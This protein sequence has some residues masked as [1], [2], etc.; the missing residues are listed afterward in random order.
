MGITTH[1]NA[2]YIAIADVH[3]GNPRLQ[4]SN[5][6]LK[7]QK[8][9]YPLLALPEDHIDHVDVLFVCGDFFDTLLTMNTESSIV[10]VK[11]I[12][13]LV[14]LAI[15]HNFLIRVIRGTYTHD[16]NQ[17]RFFLKY[18]GR[19]NNIVKVYETL[20]MEYIESIDKW[21]MYTPDNLPYENQMS[22]MEDIMRDNQ[23]DQ[24]DILVNHGYFDFELPPNVPIPHNMLVSEEVRRKIIPHGFC[25]SGHVHTPGYCDGVISIGSFDRFAHGEEGCK[26]GFYIIRDRNGVISQEHVDNDDACVFA[27]IV[28][29]DNDDP[30]HNEYG[31][32]EKWFKQL[33]SNLPALAK[34]AHVRL[35]GDDVSLV[36]ACAKLAR[37][38]YP[39]VIIDKCVETTKDQILDNVN[40]HLEDLPVITKGNVSELMLPIIQ[41]QYPNATLQDVLDVLECCEKTSK[42]EGDDLS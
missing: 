31:R 19:D 41:K 1:R 21:V 8:N 11:I 34:Q 18:L 32:F 10:A 3:I 42:K 22:V 30:D 27:T 37:T 24:I 9:L 26:K 6:Y 35:K 36:E 4:P 39:D 28:L 33:T 25:V 12:D 29:K 2:T 38:L 40:T 7:M 23:L 15:K 20:S 13:D 14:D 16:R 17:S 5:L